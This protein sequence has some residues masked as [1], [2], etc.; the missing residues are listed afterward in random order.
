MIQ[1]ILEHIKPINKELTMIQS[2]DIIKTIYTIVVLSEDHISVLDYY[3]NSLCKRFPTKG[4]LLTL[5][6]NDVSDKELSRILNIL[7]YTQPKNADNLLEPALRMCLSND[8]YRTYKIL[9]INKIIQGDYSGMLP[10]IQDLKD[11]I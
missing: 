5:D 6:K 2:H 4:V 1:T 9:L 10:I 11:G 3:A 8:E 7:Q